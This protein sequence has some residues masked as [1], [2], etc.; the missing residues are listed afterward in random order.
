MRIE[1]VPNQGFA[2]ISLTNAGIAHINKLTTPDTNDPIG[3]KNNANPANKE[4]HQS[5]RNLPK[6]AIFYI[7]V[8][9]CEL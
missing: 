4:G 8:Q 6:F 1:A 2:A 3:V 7:F 5:F 9:T